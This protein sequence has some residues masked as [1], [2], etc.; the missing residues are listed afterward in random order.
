MLR[1]ILLAFFA[2]LA[3]AC[4]VAAVEGAR[5]SSRRDLI[6]IR[7][8]TGWY[9]LRLAGGWLHVLRA[10]PLRGTPERVGELRAWGAAL[11]NRDI[12][13]PDYVWIYPTTQSEAA[14]GLRR[15]GAEAWPLLIAAL[16]NP[17]QFAAAHILLGG[18][19]Y[20]QR[21]GAKGGPGD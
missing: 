8:P 12:A 4:A 1:R 13:W 6:T 9:R 10:E 18:R 17:R 16:D 14:E 19:Y 21:P 20:A 7:R 15:A 3:I 11:D 5:N 2:A